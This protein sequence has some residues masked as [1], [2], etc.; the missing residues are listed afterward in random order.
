VDSTGASSRAR[1]GRLDTRDA[2]AGPMTVVSRERLDNTA[3][4]SDVPPTVVARSCVRSA[5][6]GK[7]LPPSYSGD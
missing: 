3:F 2:G 5:A 4:R 1:G 7:V 6:P